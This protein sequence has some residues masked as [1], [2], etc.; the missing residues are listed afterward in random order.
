MA[1]IFANKDYMDMFGLKLKEGR[2]WN[3]QDLFAQ[4]KMIINETAQKL[5]HIKNIDETSL[6]TEARLWW[7]TGVALGK[8]PPIS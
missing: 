3:D 2:K 6:Q 1:V 7:S 5:F 4:Y 8:N